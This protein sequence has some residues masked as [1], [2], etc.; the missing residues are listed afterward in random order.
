MSFRRRD[1]GVPA[2]TTSA[3]HDHDDDAPRDVASS[4]IGHVIRI[5]KRVEL[6][7]H[8]VRGPGECIA[9]IRTDKR[10]AHEP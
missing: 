4:A 7:G 5:E 2:A 1:G 6:T 9:L 3:P 8:P 10:R